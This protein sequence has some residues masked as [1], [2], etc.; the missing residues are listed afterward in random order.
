MYT[1]RIFTNWTHQ[2]NLTCIKKQ[3]MRSDK[4]SRITVLY[5][6]PPKLHRFW[7]SPTDKAAFV[8]IQNPA[9]FGHTVG[10]KTSE[11]GPI[12]EDKKNSFI[13]LESLLFQ[14]GIVAQFNAKRE[15]LSLWFLLQGK[16]EQVNEHL[17][18]L[19]VWDNAKTNKQ[20]NFFL[21]PCRILSLDIWLR[22]REKLEQQPKI[23]ECWFSNHFSDLIMKI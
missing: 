11:I 5:H 6:L 19:A 9:K 8:E 16:W 14:G 7:Q 3:A 12:E 20:T 23:R 4:N 17:V 18:S 1:W 22:G 2:C 21:S 10:A 13:L 15:P